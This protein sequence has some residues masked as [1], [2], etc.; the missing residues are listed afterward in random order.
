MPTPNIHRAEEGADGYGQGK[1]EQQ[2]CYEDAN[3]PRRTE[4]F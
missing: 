3:R 1:P 2:R 4:V